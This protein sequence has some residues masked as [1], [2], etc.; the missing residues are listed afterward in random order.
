MSERAIRTALACGGPRMAVLER[1][2][3]R[4]LPQ[5]LADLGLTEIP[6]R[7]VVALPT[8]AVTA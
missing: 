7:G 2:W 1:I 4:E 5:A 3:N 6:V 8:Q